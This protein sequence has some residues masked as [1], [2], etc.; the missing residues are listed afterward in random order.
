MKILFLSSR[1]P[2]EG[3]AGGHTIVYQRIRR[4]AERGH[5]VGLACFCEDEHRDHVNELKPALI[6]MEM[7][8]RPAFRRI[9]QA[10]KYVYS[11]VPPW[12]AWAHSR[13]MEQLVGNMVDRTRYDAVIAEFSIMGQYLYRNP[14]LPATRRIISCHRSATM[15]FRKSIELFGFSPASIREWIRM[16]GLQRFEFDMYRSAD[17]MIVLTPE[18]KYWLLNSAPNLRISVVP[19]AVDIDYFVPRETEPEE[20]AIIFT[21]DYSDEPN[22]DAV[23]WF[24]RKSWPDIKTTM[25]E[26]KF[27]IVGPNPPAEFSDAAKKDNSVIVTGRVQDIRPYLAKAQVFI[28]P[29]RLGNGMRGKVLEAMSSGIPVVSTTLGVEGIPA[30]TGDNC[31]L[32]DTSGILTKNVLLMLQDK[33]LR[34]SIA[35]EAQAMVRRRFSWHSEITMLEDVLSEVLESAVAYH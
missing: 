9:R 21:G 35:S 4:L 33:S 13:Q 1:L 24:L 32:G 25:P 2:H 23:S 14:W 27:Y 10:A 11:Q 6:E 12:Y 26:T 7:L 30:Q 3:I 29:V 5:A 34:S 18:E 31:L 28:C 22:C 19:N 15:M 16:K 20:A 8:P 17:R